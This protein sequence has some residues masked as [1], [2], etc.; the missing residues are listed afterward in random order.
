MP[1]KF[2]EGNYYDPA[3]PLGNISSCSAPSIMLIPQ[4]PNMWDIC[5]CGVSHNRYCVTCVLPIPVPAVRK[6]DVLQTFAFL[7]SKGVFPKSLLLTRWL[8]YGILL[9]IPSKYSF[10]NF[11][12][13]RTTWGPTTPLFS[14]SIFI[15][16]AIFLTNFSNF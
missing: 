16:I 4:Q 8:V 3:V 11:P 7:L 2:R 5:L 14:N 10:P 9:L 15:Y 6:K 12:F 13:G 1:K